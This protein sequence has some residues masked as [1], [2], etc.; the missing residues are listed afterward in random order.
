MLWRLSRVE[1]GHAVCAGLVVLR[2]ASIL[3]SALRAIGLDWETEDGGKDPFF[4]HHPGGELPHAAGLAA[5]SESEGGEGC[6]VTFTIVTCEARDAGGEVHYRMTVFLTEG[7]VGEW[8]V[9]GK[10]EAEQKD[11]LLAMIDEV[12]TTVASCCGS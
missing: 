4:I 1:C 9:S 3:R 12:S 5:A 10:L 7:A 8:L 11:P 2:S 6:D